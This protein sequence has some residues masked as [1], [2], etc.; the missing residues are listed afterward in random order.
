MVDLSQFGRGT[1]VLCYDFGREKSLAQC[2]TPPNRAV[3]VSEVVEHRSLSKLTTNQRLFV[4]T[5]P[6]AFLWSLDV[7]GASAVG[8]SRVVVMPNL[9]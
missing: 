4:E 8:S 2:A 5:S 6:R 9:E 1:L 3:L 7:N